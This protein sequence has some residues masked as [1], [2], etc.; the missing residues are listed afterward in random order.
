M[1]KQVRAKEEEIQKLNR[2]IEDAERNASNC[3]SNNQKL[4][5][6]INKTEQ[7]NKQL[8]SNAKEFNDYVN[9][10]EKYIEG[11][12]QKIQQLTEMNER[13]KEFKRIYSDTN[14]CRISK[15]KVK[16]KPSKQI[17]TS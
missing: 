10:M 12:E 1:E 11:S 7:E 8:K 13:I 15:R 3:F 14:S 4:K 9:K 5:A 17:L 2:R 6:E 16:Q